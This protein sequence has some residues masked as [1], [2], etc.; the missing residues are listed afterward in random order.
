[1]SGSLRTRRSPSRPLTNARVRRVFQMRRVLAVLAVLAGTL[2][3]GLVTSHPTV[4][5]ATAP[6]TTIYDST[7]PAVAQLPSLAYQA[8]QA[9]EI[10]N[11]IQFAPGTS[12]T[13]NNVV[14]SMDSWG[15]GT[16]GGGRGGRRRSLESDARPPP[17]HAILPHR[18]AE[19]EA[20]RHGTDHG[21]AS[22]VERQ[23]LPSGRDRRARTLTRYCDDPARINGEGC[24]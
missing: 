8:T 19:C 5:G 10:G 17:G 16:S 9:T 3:M 23:A 12:R 6:T 14:V 21:D 18:F 22:I 2:T 20:R 7:D 1:M 11:Q 24:R 15:C 4:A 13:L